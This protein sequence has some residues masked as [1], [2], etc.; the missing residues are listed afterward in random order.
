MA[1]GFVRLCDQE[2]DKAIQHFEIVLAIESE[3]QDQDLIAIANFWIGRCLRRRGRYHDALGYVVKAREAAIKSKHFATVAVIQELEGWILYQEG[4]LAEGAKTIRQAEDALLE[5]DDYVARGNLNSV[6]GRISRRSGDYD[7]ALRRF[8]L[9]IEEY[10]KRDEQHRN[11]ARCLV[12]IAFVKRLVALELSDKIDS[13]ASRVRKRTGK[14]S[15]EVFDPQPERLR[16]MA[17]RK[18]ALWNLSEAVAIYGRHHDHSGLGNVEVSCGYLHLDDGDFDLAS[19]RAK[20][21]YR[22]G[23]DEEGTVLKTRARILQSAIEYTK[24]VEQIVDSTNP[25]QS[26]RLASEYAQEA[27]ELAKATQNRPLI[28]QAYVTLGL[29][30]LNDGDVE[31]ARDCQ[32]QVEHFLKAGPR[33]YISRQLHK[34]KNDISKVGTIEPLL[35]EWSRGSVR[36]KTFRQVTE[37][38]AGIVIPRIWEREGRKVSRVAAQLSISPKKV[39]RLLRS[40]GYLKGPD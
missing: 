37:E 5:T 33:D 22:R 25:R 8:E 24:V 28:A 32:N 40:Q 11:V 26:S 6:Y 2:D 9:A 23:E 38:F 34:L 35:R 39:R 10:K 29:A 12:N 18:E 16:V 15:T 3:I 13:E 21:A 17:L 27:A 20:A 1:A 7:E 4:K 36:N 30:L 31:A 14:K 19:S